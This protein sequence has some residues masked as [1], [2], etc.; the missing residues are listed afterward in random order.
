MI[1][2]IK[3]IASTIA[4]TFKEVDEAN[5]GTPECPIKYKDYRAAK[6]AVQ[7]LKKQQNSIE[8]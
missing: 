2:D 4:G 3:A 7:A 5:F 6:D 1:A 8:S